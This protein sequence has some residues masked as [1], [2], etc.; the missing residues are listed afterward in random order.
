M[1]LID[2]H[3]VS[4]EYLKYTF[5][6]VNEMRVGFR[7]FLSVFLCVIVRLKM[8]QARNVSSRRPRKVQKLSNYSSKSQ[9][10]KYL[11]G[12]PFGFKK[13]FPDRKTPKRGNLRSNAV[14]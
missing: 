12:G 6:G 8:E 2:N 1:C 13:R 3:R 14:L 9:C 7:R 4:S 10:Q 5:P 11:E